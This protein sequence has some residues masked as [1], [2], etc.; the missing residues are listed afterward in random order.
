MILWF[1]RNNVNF[2]VN[3]LIYL[4]NQSWKLTTV[5]R[6]ICRSCHHRFKLWL[7]NVWKFALL[8]N[9]AALLDCVSVCIWV[10]PAKES[11]SILEYSEKGF[12]RAGK[13]YCMSNHSSAANMFQEINDTAA[14]DI[15]WYLIFF[16][17]YKYTFMYNLMFF[18]VSP[19]ISSS[20]AG[21][22][23]RTSLFN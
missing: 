20:G 8:H 1:Q 19:W 15:F 16:K 5:P 21:N 12:F 7:S 23:G 3:I 11:T 18:L 2:V 10:I 4:T 9:C 6:S 14:S 22:M 13:G 17:G